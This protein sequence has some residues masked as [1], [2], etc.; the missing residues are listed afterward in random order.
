M[1]IDLLGNIPNDEENLYVWNNVWEK[2][3]GTILYDTYGLSVLP[4]ASFSF[5]FRIEANLPGSACSVVNPHSNAVLDLDGDCLA[6][7]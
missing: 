6:G 4:T 3:N 2:S 5:N 1:R 7:S